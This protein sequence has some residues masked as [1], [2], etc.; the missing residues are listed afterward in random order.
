MDISGDQHDGPEVSMW[1]TDSE[2]TYEQSL[3]TNTFQFQPY[4]PSD[5]Y[6]M[7]ER[8]LSAKRLLFP[9]RTAGTRQSA[10][11]NI[12]PGSSCPGADR[13]VWRT[14]CC[15][16]RSPRGHCL[17]VFGTTFP[18]VLVCVFRW[19]PFVSHHPLI[20]IYFFFKALKC[21]KQNI[22]L[23]L[24]IFRNEGFSFFNILQGYWIL[25]SSFQLYQHF[26]KFGKITTK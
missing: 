6:Y 20:Y 7:R 26:A 11:C 19:L 5:C 22:N 1:C 13:F 25:N 4:S 12:Y 16:S 9:T 15:G 10:R 18:S 14:P 8:H 2:Y 23:L 24:F 3:Q 21:A 17:A